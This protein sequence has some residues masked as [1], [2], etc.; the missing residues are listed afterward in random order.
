MDHSQLKQWWGVICE[1]RPQ[2]L[3]DARRPLHGIEQEL[4]EFGLSLLELPTA[5]GSSLPLATELKPSFKNLSDA[6][7]LALRD[8]KTDPQIVSLWAET[9]M[10]FCEIKL[11]SLKSLAKGKWGAAEA[12]GNMLHLMTFFLDCGRAAD[13]PRFLNI[14]LKLLDFRWIVDGQAW[15]RDLKQGGDAALSALF[16]FRLLLLSEFAVAQLCKASVLT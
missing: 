14:V 5:A 8:C 9:L 4:A 16:Q 13:D 3:A 10:Q 7:L 2:A 11:S 6:V 15:E 1:L 12:R